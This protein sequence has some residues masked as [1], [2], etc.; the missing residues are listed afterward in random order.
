MSIS[1][2]RQVK[3]GVPEKAGWLLKLL[4][5]RERLHLVHELRGTHVTSHRGQGHEELG[6]LEVAEVVHVDEVGFQNHVW[7]FRRQGQQIQDAGNG[8]GP[9]DNTS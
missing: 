4:L 8:P 6:P 9:H 1:A 7:V 3:E 5:W 2:G